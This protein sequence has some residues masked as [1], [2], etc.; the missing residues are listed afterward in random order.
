MFGSV[1][2][3]RKR[4]RQSGGLGDDAHPGGGKRTAYAADIDAPAIQLAE[5]IGNVGGDQV[6]DLLLQRLLC[7]QRRRVAHRLL[8][9]IGVASAQFG[10][11]ADR[12]D[13]IVERLF[14]TRRALALLSLRRRAADGDRR[15]RTEVGAGRHGGDVG[16]VDD[17]GPRAGGVGARRRDIGDDRHRT[18]EDRQHDLAHR[19]LQAPWRIE[20]HDHHG[21]VR[22]GGFVDAASHVVG[23][24]RTDRPADSQ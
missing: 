18:G 13:R 15:R 19:R 6:D 22:V 4:A 20:L 8:R 7:G 16:G 9:P 23:G 1:M 24:G 10:P 2:M 12:G 11:A 5:Q 17:E 14:G 21:C 3:A